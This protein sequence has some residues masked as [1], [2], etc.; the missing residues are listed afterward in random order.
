MKLINR[1]NRR[2]G[3]ANRKLRQAI[4]A[5]EDAIASLDDMADDLPAAAVEPAQALR[6]IH[7]QHVVAMNAMLD[8]RAAACAALTAALSDGGITVQDG[9]GK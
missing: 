3:K 4:A 9:G 8:E 6:E 5:S 2:C 1:A 7:V